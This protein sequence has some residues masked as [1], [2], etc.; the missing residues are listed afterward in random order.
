MDNTKLDTLTSN[1]YVRECDVNQ[2][3]RNIC[4]S[5]N[6]SYGVEHG[7]RAKEFANLTKNLSKVSLK[8]TNKNTVMQA[9]FALEDHIRQLSSMS[10]EVKGAIIWGGLWV[11]SEAGFLTWDDMK[12]LF[13]E[14]MSK[15][16][17]LQ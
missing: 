1:I 5:W 13:G 12:K 10:I 16:M 17:K 11:V 3:L 7:G 2:A 9:Y 4:E 14:F 6:T 8:D 15:Q